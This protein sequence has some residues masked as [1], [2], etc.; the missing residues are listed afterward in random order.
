MHNKTTST[1]PGVPNTYDF[2]HDVLLMHPGEGGTY[3]VVRW[4]CPE[5]GRYRIEGGFRGLD[6]GPKSDVDVHVRKNLKVDLFT[7]VLRGAQTQKPIDLNENLNEGDT[8]DFIV[9]TGPSKDHSNDSTGLRV[10]ITRSAR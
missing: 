8:L 4:I 6:W 7:D 2:P 9:G 5:N 10:T 3:D 1:I